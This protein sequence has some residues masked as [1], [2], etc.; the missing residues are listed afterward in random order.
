MNF[1]KYVYI[2]QKKLQRFKEVMEV[3]E[4]AEGWSDVN[5]ETS[6]E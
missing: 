1:V 5:G 6:E 2:Y 3:K 4:E